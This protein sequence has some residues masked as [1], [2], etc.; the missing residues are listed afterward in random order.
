MRILPIFR[1][2]MIA[3]VLWFIWWCYNNVMFIKVIE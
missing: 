3:A 2:A 1:I